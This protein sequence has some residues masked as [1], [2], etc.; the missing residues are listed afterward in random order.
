MNIGTVGET[1]LIGMIARWVRVQ[2]NPKGLIKG[3][4]DDGATVRTS[5]KTFITTD[6]FVEGVH[7]RPGWG[8]PWQFGWKALAANVSDVAAGGAA[9]LAAVVSLALPP[10][11]PVKWPEEFYAGLMACARIYRV[12]VAGGNLSRASECSSHI[13]VIGRSPSR[14]VG[15]SGARPGDLLAVTGALGGSAAGLAALRRGWSDAPAREAI[16]RHLVPRPRAAAG[17][18]LGRLASAMLDISDGLIR[19]AGHL[20]AA[21]GVRVVLVPGGIPIHPAADALAAR[22]RIRPAELALGSG[23]EYELLA[24]IPRRRWTAA[25]RAVRRTG[26]PLT[27]IG[28]CRKGRGV[29]I[30]G[31]FSATGWDH[32]VRRV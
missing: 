22:L 21:S 10:D 31:G 26:L 29:A 11:L 3:I 5:A 12:A 20:A 6:A 23:E 17:K 4:G 25:V 28:E 14:L 19:D 8:R 1:K 15:R 32:F 27:V 16:F 9:P 30:T 2:G 24:A 18:I 13:T 7:F